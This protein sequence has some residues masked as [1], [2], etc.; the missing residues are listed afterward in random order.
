MKS[1]IFQALLG[2]CML[3][4]MTGCPRFAHVEIYNNTSAPLVVRSSGVEKTIEV[5][6][7]ARLRFTGE[8]FHVESS[9]G[10]WSY[11]RNIPH[12]GENGPFFDGTLRLQVGAN[13]AVHA[14]RVG[15]SPP[16]T[17]FVEQPNGYPLQPTR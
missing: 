1:A 11:G 3:L 5:G 6:K 14:L 12:N 10:R 2:C 9:L 8:S 17:D 15:Q 13:G 7:S 4:L 16:Q